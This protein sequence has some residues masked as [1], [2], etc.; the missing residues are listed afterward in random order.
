MHARELDEKLASGE[1][2]RD[3]DIIFTK[4]DWEELQYAEKQVEHYD[5]L[6]LTK[7]IQLNSTYGALLSPHFRFGRKELGASVTACGRQITTHMIETIH[8]LLEPDNHQKLVKTTEVEKDGRVSHVY[9]MGGDTVI[10]GDTD[11]VDGASLVK[12][13]LGEMTIERLFQQIG[14]VHREGEKEY[15]VP[16]EPVLTPCLDDGKIVQKEIEAVYRHRVRKGRF[17]VTLE[18]GRS[19]VVTEDHSIMVLRNGQLIAVK[20]KDIDT[21]TDLAI[22]L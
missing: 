13:S 12:T 16:S 14:R 2:V 10:Y 15:A 8:S 22:S 9:V 20:A 6:Q 1:L 4:A 5:L 11:S 17:K 7:K 18:D 3:G 21:E 19:V